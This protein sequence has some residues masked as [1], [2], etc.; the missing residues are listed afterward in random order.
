LNR[1]DTPVDGLALTPATLSRRRGLETIEAAY[2]A[3][4]E[5]RLEHQTRWA[6]SAAELRRIDEQGSLVLGAVRS[7]HTANPA[8][9]SS[10]A[11]LE[12]FLSD[13]RAKLEALRAALTARDVAALAAFERHHAELTAELRAR[14]E[15]QASVPTKPVVRVMLRAMPGGR[16]ILHAERLT[17]DDAV[18]VFFA[19]TGRVPSRYGFLFDDSTDDVSAPPPWLYP[20]EGVSPEQTRPRPAE[21]RALLDSRESVWPAKGMLPVT[22]PG[23]GRLARWLQRGAVM[24]AEIAEPDG[25]RNLLSQDEAER[26]L[27][28]LLSLKLAGRLEVELVHG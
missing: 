22:L 6:L 2:E 26:M 19:L 9:S 10:A 18:V 28:V 5:L 17:G 14:I 3:L 4:T 12:G 15:R 7:A 1:S 13:S 24:E 27:S 21:L 20:D 8:P 25:F 23:D 16:R 11:G